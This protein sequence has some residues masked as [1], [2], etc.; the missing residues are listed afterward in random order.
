LPNNPN[1]TEIPAEEIMEVLGSSAT[2]FKPEDLI[3][4]AISLD[5]TESIQW[6]DLLQKSD[7]TP[8]LSCL[9]IRPGEIENVALKIKL[10][11]YLSGID[12]PEAASL[13][14]CFLNDSNKVVM[15]E[16]LKA[17]DRFSS[18][19]DLSALLAHIRSMS[20]AEEGLALK[21]IARHADRNLIEHLSDFVAGISSRLQ[22]FFVKVIVDHADG[23]SLEGFLRRL[24][25]AEKSKQTETIANLQ[26]FSNQNISTAA[27]GLLEHDNEFVR[28]CARQLAGDVESDQDLSRIEKFA[29]S[30][31]P[32][33]R[34]RAIQSIGKSADRTGVAILKK[35]A[36]KWPEDSVAILKAVRQLG[37]SKGL[38]VA[39]NC[40]VS[41]DPIVQRSSL[42]TIEAIVT[43]KHAA[44]IRENIIREIPKLTDEM[45]DYAK[46]LVI[47]LTWDFGLPRI[48]I[49][50]NTTAE[51]L[52]DQRDEDD[53]GGI[54]WSPLVS[55]LDSLE[56]GT[57]WMDRYRI[58]KEIGRGMMGRVLL[59]EDDFVDEK[60]ILK[61]MQPELVSDA[62]SIERFKREVKY[63]R[64]IGHKNVIRVHDL[65]IQD[66]M[67][68]ISMEYFKSRGLEA[69]LKETGAFDERDGLKV[70]YQVSNGMAAAHE[71]GVIHRDLKPSNILINRDGLVKIVDFGIASATS[72]T[73]STL[74]Q[75]GSIVGSPAYL[76]PERVS[77]EEA[78]A[79]CD[80]YSLGIIAYYLLCGKLPYRGS[81]MEVLNQ[82]RLG[83]AVP[84]DEI[85]RLVSRETTSLVGWM[86]R[87]DSTDRISS[88]ESVRNEIR[89]ILDPDK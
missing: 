19:F 76:A 4:H 88:M 35:A 26:K 5:S 25:E 33:V 30:D 50:E 59:V 12:Q 54:D 27:R 72:G 61:F 3:N 32:Q 21:I 79:R 49:D 17:L 89:K 7:R 83:T 37:F 13:S 80:I 14:C 41:G 68:A 56:P 46:S 60:M 15:F 66:E 47:K 55:I 75:T 36:R 85:N 39:L 87:A 40:L 57:V 78:T 53:P 71:Q 86:M 24:S 62:S 18:R 2:E 29:L 10:L 51:E 82:H 67:C 44:A 63:A 9:N 48:Q 28:D 70:L 52:P 84:L 1:E 65:L 69:I 43:E 81:T 42:E 34:Q 73:D 20:P 38:E 58:V 11:D 23:D 22:N 6:L 64:R 16:A 31:D 77:D 8:R 74:T 45:K